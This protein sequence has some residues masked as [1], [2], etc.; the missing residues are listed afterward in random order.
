[1]SL[2]APP[3]PRS[4]TEMVT[5]LLAPPSAAH[6]LS[7][8]VASSSGLTSKAQSLPL[9][10]DF[11]FHSVTR[12]PLNATTTPS[13][14]GKRSAVAP[15]SVSSIDLPVSSAIIIMRLTRSLPALDVSLVTSE[16]PEKP[17]GGRRRA[18]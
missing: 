13:S 8:S 15:H 17:R 5:A 16:M 9:L 4:L 6:A 18:R 7:R 14:I 2:L 1:M 3:P 11:V 12:S 10:S